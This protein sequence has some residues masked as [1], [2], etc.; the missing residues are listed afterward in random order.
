MKKL[1]ITILLLSLTGCSQKLGAE[2]KI[3]DNL[4]LKAEKDRIL[5]HRII[6]NEVHYDYISN[7]EANKADITTERSQH[8]KI[9]ETATSTTYK[10]IF[11]Q[12]DEFGKVDNKW[13]KIKKNATTTLD[14][15]NKEVNKITLLNL[16]KYVLADNY[17]L[18]TGNGWIQ[19]SGDTWANCKAATTGTAHYS[20]TYMYSMVSGSGISS[21]FGIY[22]CFIPF[23]TSSLDAGAIISSASVYTYVT[24]VYTDASDSY[25]Y[26]AVVQ[27][28]QASNSSLANADYDN[29]GTTKGSG[30]Y[31][32]SSI[33]TGDNTFSLNATGI[34]WITKGGWTYLALDEGH[35]ITN[36]QPS[37]SSGQKLGIRMY[38]SRGTTAPYLTVN[39]TLPSTYIPSQ[40]SDLI[41]TEE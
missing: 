22:R 23:D 18:G 11:Y 9:K 17:S 10:A 26:M 14:V 39:Y 8:F 35:D 33:S 12:E 31:T 15:W 13:F 25:S 5:N 28:T 19:C 38:S 30:N 16:I 32:I 37:L 36:N 34:G 20:E 1:L 2:E 7:E 3:S 21:T 29:I 41:V 27:S 6:N 24:N 4:K 40:E